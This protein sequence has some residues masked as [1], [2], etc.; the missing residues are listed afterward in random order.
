MVE[1]SAGRCL[2]AGEARS[3]DAKLLPVAEA[4]EQTPASQEGRGE[5]LLAALRL[6]EAGVVLCQSLNLPRE[7]TVQKRFPLQQAFLR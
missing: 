3:S 1:L 4:A 2:V 6:G 7:A 5:W